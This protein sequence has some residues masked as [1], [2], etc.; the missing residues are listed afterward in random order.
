MDSRDVSKPNQISSNTAGYG[1]IQPNA[2]GWGTQAPSDGSPP[3][4]DPWSPQM[5]GASGSDDHNSESLSP[6]QDS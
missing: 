5:V 6:T 3:Q 1:E 2:G 4:V